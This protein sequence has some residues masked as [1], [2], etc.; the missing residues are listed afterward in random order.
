MKT[1]R[2]LNGYLFIRPIKETKTTGGLELISKLDEQDRYSKAEVVF[3]GEVLNEGDIILYDK[4]NGHGFQI[5]DEL[6]TV[7]RLGD[8][9]GVL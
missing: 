3:C 4:N 6:L 5:N 1:V 7:L 9:V 8:V 2:P